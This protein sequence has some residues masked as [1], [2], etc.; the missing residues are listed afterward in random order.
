M[1]MCIPLQESCAQ[2][3]PCPADKQQGKQT[4]KEFLAKER[5]IQSLQDQY[6]MAVTDSTKDQITSLTGE[7][8]KDE[9]RQLLENI[10]WLQDQQHY[11]I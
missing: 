2:A 8:Y 7:A 11:S 9:C 1:V 5:S 6:D 10:D 4:L 3:S